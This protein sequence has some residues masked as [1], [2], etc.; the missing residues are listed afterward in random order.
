VPT[1]TEEFLKRFFPPITKEKLSEMYELRST[2]SWFSNR[3]LPAEPLQGDVFGPLPL[4]HFDGT[5]ELQIM[6]PGLL[7]SGGCDFDR[8]PVVLVAPCHPAGRME[9]TMSTGW[10]GQARRQQ[11]S[12]VLHLPAYGGREELFVDL[13]RIQPFPTAAI[14]TGIAANRVQCVGSFSEPG[15]TFFLLKLGWHL[16]RGI[17]DE[18]PKYPAPGP[19]SRVASIYDA[20]LYVCRVGWIRIGLLRRRSGPTSP[21]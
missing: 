7:I 1:A 21:A 12:T 10:L 5:D 17:H 20:V 8:D 2:S 3:V 9:S 19:L 16:F 14:K 6:L 13:S 4:L 11:I 15:F 18:V